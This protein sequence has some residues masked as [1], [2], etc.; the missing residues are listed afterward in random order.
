MT[1]TKYW[2]YLVCPKTQVSYINLDVYIKKEKEKKKEWPAYV[3]CYPSQKLSYWALCSLPRTA[4]TNYH[5]PGVFKHQK[6]IFSQFWYQKPKTKAFQG[7]ALKEKA[8]PL[9]LAA[10]DSS[11]WPLVCDTSLQLLS[12]SS[13]GL[14]HAWAKCFLADAIP[15][16]T[17][18][19]FD[20]HT[21]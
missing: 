4:I 3:D 17:I 19:P 6:L 18:I 2:A 1:T 12:R 15:R 11:W 7:H 5:K 16:K 8:V 14:L 10:A 9:P 13:H 20:G 21:Q